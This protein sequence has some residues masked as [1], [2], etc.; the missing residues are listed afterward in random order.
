[1]VAI[2]KVRQAVQEFYKGR[3]LVA[4]FTAGTQGIGEYS[5]VTLA[6]Q[7]KDSNTPLRVYIVGRN[8]SKAESVIAKCRQHCAHGEFRF[9]PSYDL[10]SII[11]VDKVSREIIRLERDEYN[12]PEPR[13]DL[14]L[15][16]QGKLL[17]G[18]RQGTPYAIYHFLFSC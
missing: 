11:D 2:A 1:M 17:F 15:L 8:Q 10:T 18:P 7:Y 4:V 5:V 12:T 3:P 14:L 6:R 9:V 16:T 13:I